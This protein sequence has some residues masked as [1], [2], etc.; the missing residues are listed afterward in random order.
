MV[1]P[2]EREKELNMLQSNFCNGNFFIIDCDGTILSGCFPKEN[3]NTE[4]NLLLRTMIITVDS[5]Y[6]ISCSN[7]KKP[8]PKQKIKHIFPLPNYYPGSFGSMT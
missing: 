5:L 2:S 7:T 6:F 1:H 3:R 4:G 8:C